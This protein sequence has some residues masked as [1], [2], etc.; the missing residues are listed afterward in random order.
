MHYLWKQSPELGTLLGSQ[1]HREPGD[2]PTTFVTILNQQEHT[3]NEC[4]AVKNPPL[5]IT[6]QVK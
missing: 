4:R 3:L 2:L 6:T 5:L 1:G